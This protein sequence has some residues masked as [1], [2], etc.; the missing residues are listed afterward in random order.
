MARNADNGNSSRLPRFGKDT[1]GDVIL[2]VTKKIPDFGSRECCGVPAVG[3][4]RESHM[5]KWQYKCAECLAGKLEYELR[6]FKEVF[7]V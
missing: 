5:D 1:G 4:W 2:K 3:I 6:F 7:D